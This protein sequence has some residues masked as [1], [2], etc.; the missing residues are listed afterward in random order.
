MAPTMTMTAKEFLFSIHGIGVRFVTASPL[1]VAPAS[2]LLR[3]FQVDRLPD[4]PPLTIELNGVMHRADIP[5]TTP[6]SAVQMYAGDGRAVG[7]ALR[8]RW[9]CTISSHE[10]HLYIDFHEQGLVVIDPIRG[11]AHGYIVRPE[12]MHFDILDSYV[13]LMVTELLRYRGLYTM[14]ATSLEKN[15]YGVLI[16]GHSGRGKTTSF[17]SLLR[18]GYRYLSDDHPMLRDMNGHVELLSFPMK[19]DVTEQTIAFFPELRHAPVGALHAGPHKRFFYVEDIY[20]HAAIGDRCTPAIILFPHVVDAEHSSLERLPR[21]RV[22]EE[23]LPQGLVAYD[24][25]VARRQFVLL[26]KLAQQVDCYRLYFGR[27]VEELPKL[28]DPLLEGRGR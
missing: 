1:M 4:G 20:A 7:D 12:A 2:L 5:V 8:Q 19:V 10:G 21:S 24:K 23:L 11:I 9:Q 17:L 16:P 15:G 26:S 14:H 22:L 13:H 6:D 18:S 3:Y 28:I 27:N 25:D